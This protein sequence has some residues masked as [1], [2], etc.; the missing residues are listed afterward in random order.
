MRIDGTSN[1]SAVA[2][3]SGPSSKGKG[4][5]VF[6]PTT[7]AG[8]KS[9]SASAPSIPIP[10]ASGIDAILALQGVDNQQHRKKRAVRHGE[11][12][13]DALE[14]MKADLLLGQIGEGHLNRLMALV[15]R[16]RQQA[17]PDLQALIDD[18]DLRAQVE[19]AKLGRFS[20]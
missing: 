6:R 19:L 18:I 8:A 20:G 13:L 15:T 9:S 1:R 4:G 2:P 16:A 10:A 5:V 7:S 14:D 17:D 11:S 3:R 12:M